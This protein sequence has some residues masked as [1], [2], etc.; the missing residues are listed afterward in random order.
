MSNQYKNR[1]GKNILCILCKEYGH[2]ASYK[3][4]TVHKE[5]VNKL[6]SRQAQLKDK[7][8]ITS[9]RFE[10]FTGKGESFAD[11][12]KGPIKKT[13][14]TQNMFS[15]TLKI[16]QNQMAKLMQVVELQNQKIEALYD[17]IANIDNEQI[18]LNGSVHFRNNKTIE[19][20]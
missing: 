15:E 11:K 14:S 1:K 19:R 3:S 17:I 5:L 13:P 18:K 6:R 8:P 7:K 16:M 10:K 9:I 2:P 12:L 4:C 20:I